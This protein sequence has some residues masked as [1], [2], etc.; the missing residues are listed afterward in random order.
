MKKNMGGIDRIL[1][2]VVAALIIVLYFMDKFTGTLGIVLLV[3]AGIFIITSL[4]SYCPLY[5]PFGINSCPIKES[6]E[7]SN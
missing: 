7:E 3:V 2:L 1:R 4:F 6:K 5:V